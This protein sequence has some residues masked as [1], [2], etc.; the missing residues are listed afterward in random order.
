MKVAAVQRTALGADRSLVAAMRGFTE[1]T[2]RTYRDGGIDA[3][4]QF[5]VGGSTSALNAQPDTLD[6]EFAQHPARIVKSAAL[7]HNPDGARCDHFLSRL[8]HSPSSVRAYRKQLGLVHRKV[9]PIP[10]KAKP[11]VQEPLL[12]EEW[13]PVLEE[14]KYGKRHGF[15]VD[16]SRFVFAAFLGSLWGFTRS[17]LPTLSGRQA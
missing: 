5:D 4:K 9:A 3:L 12:A 13:N 6:A 15:F 7:D 1:T 14:A 17:V 10:T 16:A 2:V 8:G 11:E